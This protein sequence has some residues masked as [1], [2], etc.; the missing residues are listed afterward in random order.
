MGK[1]QR[2][3]MGWIGALYLVFQ[4]SLVLG[5][6]WLSGHFIIFT[7]LAAGIAWPSWLSSALNRATSDV[8][9]HLRLWRRRSLKPC[10]HPQSSGS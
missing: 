5:G 1:T 7:L 3:D 6:L 2:M 4:L 9:C 10:A 8:T